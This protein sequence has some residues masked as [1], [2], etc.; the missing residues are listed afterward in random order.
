M[1]VRFEF[2]ET[3]DAGPVWYTHPTHSSGFVSSSC[4]AIPSGEQPR[5]LGVD[6]LPDAHC[7]G[8]MR[9]SGVNSMVLYNGQC[10]PHS[11][12]SA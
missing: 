7:L 5:V 8:C 9:I 3:R 4:L 10:S 2:V 12:A 11:S 1:D 6:V